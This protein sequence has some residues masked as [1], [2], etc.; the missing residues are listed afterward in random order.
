MAEWIYDFVK[1]IVLHEQEYCKDLYKDIDDIDM[2]EVIKYIEYRANIILDNL[3]LS[4]IFDTKKNPMSWI[5]A[6]DPQ[7]RN[8]KKEDFFEKRE[9]NYEL[10]S[11]DNGW[12]DL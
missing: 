8:R 3:G 2:Y 6:F 5:N 4:K 7:N 11:G 1:E 12:D 9:K 10:T